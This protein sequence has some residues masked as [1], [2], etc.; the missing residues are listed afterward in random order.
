MYAADS[1]MAAPMRVRMRG[2]HDAAVVRH[3]QP[4]VRVGGDRVRAADA[5][6][7]GATRRARAAQNPNAPSTC[8]HAPAR[9]RR[10]GDRLDRIERAGVDVAGLRADD[11]GPVGCESAAASSSA[12]IRPCSSVGTGAPA[13]R[14]GPA[15]AAR[16]RSCSGT[17]SL[18]K[19]SIGGAPK[20]PRLR[21]PIRQRPARDVVP[22][23][24]AVKF[25]I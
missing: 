21:R 2:E 23:A 4:F 8:S 10:V 1:V 13:R 16:R 20:S 25:A 12:R 17:S 3:V 22:P 11:A 24:I 15:A 6:T 18:T 19:T 14:P 7:R 9:A 5:A